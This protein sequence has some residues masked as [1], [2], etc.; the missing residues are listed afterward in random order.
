MRTTPLF[1]LKLSALFVFT[2]IAFLWLLKSVELMTG[3]SLVEFGIL[4]GK[5]SGMLGILLAPL[6]HGSFEHLV[7]NTLP[8]FILGV[9]ILHIY[10]R[11][12]FHSLPIIY[13]VSGIG[14]WLFARPVY[15]IGASGLS[16][17]LMFFIFVIGILRR[18]RLAI[19][20]SMLVF[21]LYGSMV[22]GILPHD[23]NISF[24][25]HFFG[26]M[27]GLVLAFIMK[28]RDP[29]I[30]VKRYAWE[31]ENDEEEDPIIGDEWRQH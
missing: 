16:Y 30:P 25:Y 22:W 31:D 21:F 9:C 15:H 7:A 13:I 11:A 18:D 2:F 29:K 20:I 23:P 1:S 6:I 10:P 24:E 28:D 5:L 19:A 4:P 27:T 12:A 17:G 3:L 8:I 26:A 14:V